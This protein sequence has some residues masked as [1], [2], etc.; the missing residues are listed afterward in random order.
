MEKSKGA[1]PFLG[2]PER[3]RVV[4][5]RQD[6]RA[7]LCRGVGA[8]GRGDDSVGIQRQV[9]AVL[10]GGAHRKEQDVVDRL[11]RLRQG[12]GLEQHG[13]AGWWEG[14]AVKR[15]RPSKAGHIYRFPIGSP[16]GDTPPTPPAC[17]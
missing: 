9:R 14:Q 1:G 16:F 8:G 15:R 17:K 7:G 10:L 6:G 11:L 4:Q 2:V 3:H 5:R 13:P 12:E